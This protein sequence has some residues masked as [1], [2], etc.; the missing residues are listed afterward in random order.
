VVSHASVPF[1]ATTESECGLAEP[2]KYCAMPKRGDMSPKDVLITYS[3]NEITW[4]FLLDR[5]GS[6]SS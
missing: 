6:H 5:K 1:F 3:T 2:T 4:L